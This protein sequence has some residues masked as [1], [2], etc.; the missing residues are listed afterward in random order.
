[1]NLAAVNIWLLCKRGKS[2]EYSDCKYFVDNN[3]FKLIKIRPCT[4]VSHVSSI[5]STF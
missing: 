1:M 3:L 5:C 4:K 2:D